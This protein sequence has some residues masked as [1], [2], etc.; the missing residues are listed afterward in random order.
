MFLKFGNQLITRDLLRRVQ[1]APDKVY[2]FIKDQEAGIRVDGDLLPAARYFFETYLPS[3][4]MVLDVETVY[5]E[6]EKLEKAV[7]DAKQKYAAQQ[8]A[9]QAASTIGKVKEF[10]RSKHVS[11]IGGGPLV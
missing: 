8:T 11:D 1:I 3:I 2:I 7:E 6:R 10:P 5:K 9:Q 4:N